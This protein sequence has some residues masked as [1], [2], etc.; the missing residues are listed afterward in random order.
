MNHR[1]AL[2][3]AICALL[4]APA[5]S[6]PDLAKIK[7]DYQAAS[8]QVKKHQSSDGPYLDNDPQ[9]PKWLAKKWALAGEWL[10]ASLDASGSVGPDQVKAAMYAL[11]PSGKPD[12]IALDATTFVVSV[13][14]DFG[15]FF[16][17]TKAA[18]HFHVAWSIADVQPVHGKPAEMLA[19]WRPENA[20]DQ[21]RDIPTAGP[22]NGALGML[23]PD[24]RGRARFYIDGIYAEP[25]GSTVPAQ[26]SVWMWDG[27]HARLLIAR[28][29]GVMLDQKV[30][31]RL[32]GELLKV[33]QKKEFRTFS[34]CGQCEGRQVDWIVRV[35]GKGIA[36]LGEASTVPELDAVDELLF[37]LIHGRSA[38]DIASPAAIKSAS[39]ILRDARGDQPAKEWMKLPTIGM[40]G[41]WTV[42]KMPG[43]EMLCFT[44]DESGTN[45]YKLIPKAGGFFIEDITR[46]DA[47]CSR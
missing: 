36:D 39:A 8:A 3:I 28:R 44:A 12:F 4:S 23:P 15:N 13:P 45:I 19:A 7:A 34:S 38:T 24:A 35:D 40:M 43:A 2:S 6:R 11:E 21:R 30:G 10:T 41:N 32:E 16:I 20:R 26:V 31:T 17:V 9:S 29:F 37:R 22:I 1:L 46:P 27:T 18:G 47:D 25:I 5:W 33:Q 42:R 14:G